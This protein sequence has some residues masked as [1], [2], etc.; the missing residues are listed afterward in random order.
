[1]LKILDNGNDIGNDS[2]GNNTVD[3][4]IE[5]KVLVPTTA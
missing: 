3:Q 4:I 2:D 5:V 1:M